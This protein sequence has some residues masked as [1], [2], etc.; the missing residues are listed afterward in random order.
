MAEKQLE[1]TSTSRGHHKMLNY[2][3]NV[4][5]TSSHSDNPVPKTVKSII[6]GQK[7]H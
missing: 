5:E 3:L 1:A 7:Y 4:G 6:D 2:E